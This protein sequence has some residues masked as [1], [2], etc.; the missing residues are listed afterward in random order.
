MDMAVL[1]KAEEKTDGHGGAR[2][3]GGGPRARRVRVATVEEDKGGRGS[4][5][6]ERTVGGE[7]ITA[8]C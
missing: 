3:G 2:R 8:C 1:G 5:A 7:P 6:K 4:E